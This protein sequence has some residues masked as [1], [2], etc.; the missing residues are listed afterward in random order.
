M[1]KQQLTYTPD[2]YTKDGVLKIAP[3]LWLI[4]IYLSRHLLI[5]LIGALSQFMGSRTGIDTSGLAVLYSSPAFIVA[6]IP[7]LVVLAVH[8]RRVPN[9]APL[10]RHLWL[11]GRWLLGAGAV[12][13]LSILVWHWS[14]GLLSINEFQIAGLVI[15]GYIITFLVRSK[16]TKHTFAEFPADNN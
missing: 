1:V 16:R 10:V 8:F 15:D 7:A 13:D 9:T 12:L 2:D 4:I 5:L 3:L 6:S 11:K 14:S